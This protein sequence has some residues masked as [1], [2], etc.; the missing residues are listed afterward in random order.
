MRT[1]A[2]ISDLHFGRIDPSVL[3]GLVRDLA[4]RKPT[5]Q[6][7]VP[8]NHDIPMYDVLRR[9]ISPLGRYRKFITDDLCP[10]FHDD[11]LMVLGINSARSF[12]HK[13]GWI[14]DAQLSDLK[15]RLC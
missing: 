2:H 15:A 12:T 8:G 5:P 10:F 1:I 9:F 6:L 11:Q 4:G 13:S 14:N 7:T 3:E